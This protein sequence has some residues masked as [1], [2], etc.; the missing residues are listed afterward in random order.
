[1]THKVTVGSLLDASF[2]T[3]RLREDSSG[4]DPDKSDNEA[5][6]SAEVTTADIV[7][8]LNSI[9][10]GRS[11]RDD[12]V[13]GAMDAYVEGLDEAEKTALFAFLKGIAQV[14][15]G[16]IPAKQAT[17]PSDAPSDVSMKKDVKS[18]KVHVK[19]N[20]I[21]APSRDS[22]EPTVSVAR[23]KAKKA[24]GSEDT[25]APAQVPINAKRPG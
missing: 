21:K 14:V 19:P 22:S 4:K 1:M 15:T 2:R 20:V 24:P 8:K 16:E 18:L 17:E 12:A 9:R 10:A 25:S 7:E 3:R 13:K 11:F 23:S 6:A 5:M